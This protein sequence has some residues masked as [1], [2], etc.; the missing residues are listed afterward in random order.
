MKKDERKAI[1]AVSNTYGST[2]PFIFSVGPKMQVPFPAG[3]GDSGRVTGEGVP[4]AEGWPQLR[5]GTAL[6]LLA[7][8]LGQ[9]T[10]KAPPLP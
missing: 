3:A 2:I 8:M 7:R 5:R 1:T 10:S 4:H 6:C 9:P